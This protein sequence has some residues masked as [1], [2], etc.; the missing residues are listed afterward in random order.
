[1]PNQ[2]QLRT[3][4]QE[5]LKLHSLPEEEHYKYIQNL[6]TTRQAFIQKLLDDLVVLFKEEYDENVTYIDNANQKLALAYFR[7][8][9]KYIKPSVVENAN[10]FKMASLMELLIIQEQIMIHSDSTRRPKI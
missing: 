7:L 8:C 9:Y 5:L 2:D 10:R 1:M 6:A 4:E 3:I